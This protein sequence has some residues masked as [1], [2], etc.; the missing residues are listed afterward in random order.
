[1][2]RSL[3]Q[4]EK[5][6]DDYSVVDPEHKVI[7]RFIRTLFSSAQLTAECAIVTLVNLRHQINFTAL[8]HVQTLLSL[9]LLC[10]HIV[11]EQMVMLG[12]PGKAADIR[13]DGHLSL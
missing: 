4:R 5:V 10:V 6:P 12:V 8:K 13:G 7:Y 1:M 2:R 11:N 3:P 9:L